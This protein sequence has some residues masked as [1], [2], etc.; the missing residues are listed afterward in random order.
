MTVGAP[1]A[2]IGG[3]FYL[4]SA[5]VLPV[6]SLYRTMRGERVA[7]GPVVRQWLLA[8]SVLGAIWLAGWLIGLWAGPALP[9]L[10]GR[11]MA[12]AIIGTTGVLATTML[13]ASVATL[14]LVLLLVRIAALLVQRRP[15]TPAD[16]RRGVP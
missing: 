3:L 12:A 13:Y 5:L 14:V 10:A 11:G 7:W 1:G 6:R 15:V 4:A 9:Q 8:L 16:R 2:G